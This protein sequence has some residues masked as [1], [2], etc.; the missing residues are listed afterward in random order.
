MEMMPRPRFEEL[1]GRLLPPEAREHVLGDLQERRAGAGSPR[2]Y[3][4]DALRVLPYVVWGQIRRAIGM[5]MLAVQ[6]ATIWAGFITGVFFTPRVS[7][8]A[9]LLNQ[10]GLTRLLIPTSCM[11]VALV[12]ADTY[13]HADSCRTYRSPVPLFI[14]VA[15]AALVQAV[16]AQ[17]AAAAGVPWA[18]FTS[19]AAYSVV[20][21]TLVRLVGRFPA[22]RT[23]GAAAAAMSPDRLLADASAL[24]RELRERTRIG[25]AGVVFVVATLVS[26]AW[27]ADLWLVR[28]WCATGAIGAVYLAAQLRAYRGQLP[29]DM[30]RASSTAALLGQYQRE[31]DR[32]REFHSGRPLWL[33]MTATMYGPAAALADALITRPDR[34]GSFAMLAILMSAFAVV[35]ARSSAAYARRYARQSAALAAAS[36]APLP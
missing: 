14:A 6:L 17:F 27:N 34:L 16:V 35:A 2:A 21:L 31:L 7:A 3:L 13:R 26:L 1:I 19:G 36:A 28:L 25:Y 8:L 15:V 18:V 32:Q 23:A 33:R 9:F 22:R 20:L 10:Q 24:Q 11:F 5:R 29:A 4:A 30:S 12:L